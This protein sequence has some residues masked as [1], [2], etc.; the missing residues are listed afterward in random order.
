MKGHW[1]RVNPVKREAIL[2][3]LHA[4][5]VLSFPNANEKSVLQSLYL[6]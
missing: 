2:K 3:D 6:G 1:S 4:T 5:G